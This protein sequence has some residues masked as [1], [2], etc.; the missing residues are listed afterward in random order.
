M[1]S[2]KIFYGERGSIS[3][4]GTR[5]MCNTVSPMT[6][7]N[8]RNQSTKEM[9]G[10]GRKQINCSILMN[11]SLFIGFFV[12]MNKGVWRRGAE[13]GVQTGEQTCGLF[14]QVS[15]LCVKPNSLKPGCQVNY[16]LKRRGAKATM[17]QPRRKIAVYN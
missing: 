13:S 10:D 12:S 14:F 11:L 7:R 9:A 4:R 3:K 15:S 17:W 16:L 1:G 2:L 6:T 5:N 8:R